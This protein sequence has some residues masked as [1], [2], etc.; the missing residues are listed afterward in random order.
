MKKQEQ[1]GINPGTASNRLVKD[2]LFKFVTDAGHV[3]FRCGLPM[4]RQN[5]SIE[6]KIAWLDSADPVG[7]YFDL[8]NIAYSHLKC[9]VEAAR[10]KPAAK[11]GT[12]SGYAK[13]CRC[14]ECRIAHAARAKRNYTPE[15]RSKKYRDSGH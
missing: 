10:S 15:A 9:N 3:C 11:C 14:D 12:A 1:L 8:N 5:F 4:T 13:G 6:H 2:I 7:L